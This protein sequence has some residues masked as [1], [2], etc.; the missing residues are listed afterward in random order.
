MFW[1]P[2]NPN[3]PA[4][5]H[6]AACGPAWSGRTMKQGKAERRQSREARLRAA[7]R[8]NLKRRKEQARG[9]DAAAETETAQESAEKAPAKPRS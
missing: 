9:R 6:V 5:V 3:Q 2:R 1:C 4:P 7:L 8:E